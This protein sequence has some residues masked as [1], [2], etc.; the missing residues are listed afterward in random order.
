MNIERLGPVYFQMKGFSR[1]V[2]DTMPEFAL[3]HSFSCSTSNLPKW[4]QLFPKT[5]LTKTLM[6]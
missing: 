6:D 4:L 5:R 1:E 3:A 2:E